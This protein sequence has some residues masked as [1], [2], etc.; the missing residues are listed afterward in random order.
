MVK[1][2]QCYNLHVQVSLL[3]ICLSGLPGFFLQSMSQELLLF[4]QVLLYKAVLTHLF[5][6]LIYK[7]KAHSSQGHLIYNSWSQKA[8]RTCSKHLID[9]QML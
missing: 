2:S 7:Q 8:W 6:N 4:G 9:V 3:T 5:S 1:S